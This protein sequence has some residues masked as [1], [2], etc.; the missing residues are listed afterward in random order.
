VKAAGATYVARWSTYHVR[1]LMRSI[2][3]A[4]SNKGFSF[5][6]VLSMCPT[7]WGHTPRDV[8][9]WIQDVMIPYYPLGNFRDK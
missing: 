6:E 4:L 3:D 8:A 2:K 9:K 7:G 1:E 5:I